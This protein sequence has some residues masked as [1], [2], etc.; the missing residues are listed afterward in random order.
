[1]KRF[2]LLAAVLSAHFVWAQGPVNN[3]AIRYVGTAPSGACSQSPPVQVLNSTGAIYTCDNG[4]WAAQ[5]GGGT[6]PGTV[7]SVSG[8]TNQIDVANGTTTP[9]ISIDSAYAPANL[10]GGAL[11]SAPYQS[12]ANTTAFITSPTTT[13]RTFVY[14]WQPSGSAIV[15][16]A[17]DLATYLASPPA[18]GGT[19]PAAATFTTA[20]A[21][22]AV[23]GTFRNTLDPLTCGSTSPPSWCS[24]TTIDAWENAANT[25]VISNGGGTIDMR[26][27]VGSYSPVA[28]MNCGNTTSAGGGIGVTLLLPPSAIFYL[29]SEAAGQLYGLVLYNNCT[30]LGTGDGGANRMQFRVHTGTPTG[31]LAAV[32]SD[33][34]PPV[35]IGSNSYVRAEGFQIFEEAGITHGFDHAPL[36]E[37]F[38]YDN[39][40]FSHIKIVKSTAGNG[41]F[42]HQTCCSAINRDVTVDCQSTASCIPLRVGATGQTTQGI[43]F[44]SMS[45][46]HA[47]SGVNNILIDGGASTYGLT[48]VNTYVEDNL[49]TPSTTPQVSWSASGGYGYLF[50]GI[51]SNNNTQNTATEYLVSI[52]TGTTQVTVLNATSHTGLCVTDTANSTNAS[53]V[54]A[55]ANYVTGPLKFGAGNSSNPGIR[56]GDS[57]PGFYQFSAGTMGIVGS[58]YLTGSQLSYG[59]GKANISSTATNILDAGAGST[60][61]ATGAY[62]ANQFDTTV[63]TVTPSATPAIVATNGLQTITLNASATPTI[64]GITAGQRITFQICQPA[65]GGPY[66]W[67]WPAA[68][69]GGNTI[70]TA[71]SACL[72]QSFDS[73]NGTTLVAESQFGA[74]GLTAGTGL[75]QSGSTVSSN[76]VYQLSFQPGLLTSVT[77]TIA[78]FSTFSKAST[79]DNLVG[80]AYTFS[81]VS[82]PTITMYEC[83]TSATCATPTAI[84]T[85]TVTAAGTRTNGTITSAAVTAGDSVGWA[86][87]A[88]TCTSLDIS[89][90]AQVHSN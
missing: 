30:V 50:N 80:S 66:T 35:G 7:T 71:A 77:G 44:L 58:G 11:G 73:I 22:T 41:I 13:G 57:G 45:L 17:L 85:V 43:T 42:I 37:Q 52:P 10:S 23:A 18:I 83:G 1:M 53:C 25:Q 12:A 75:A 51:Y 24:G 36:E 6:S 70:P 68:I 81:C 16:A 78:I 20:A 4:T 54:A 63:T 21:A 48:F 29:D 59:N 28:T 27:A 8:T 5:T 84:G 55:A 40:D 62:R 33:P 88:G 49:T 19:T 72:Q 79:V 89:A 9:V 26:G 61:G 64:S 56:F 82:N 14:A 3:P 60:A 67:A 65:S 69:I 38:L 46:D 76:A 39:S 90:T 47:G 2:I 32:A 34:S 31:F 15:P 87:T 74:N 86:L